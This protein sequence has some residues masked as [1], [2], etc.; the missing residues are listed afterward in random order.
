MTEE[1]AG[2]RWPDRGA[3]VFPR[4]E[5]TVINIKGERS[6]RRR[7]ARVVRKMLIASQEDDGKRLVASHRC[8]KFIPNASKRAFALAFAS[9]RSATPEDPPSSPERARL[10]VSIEC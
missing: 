6:L 10:T 1:A 4:R 9:I 2:S 3:C 7:V 5:G 8:R